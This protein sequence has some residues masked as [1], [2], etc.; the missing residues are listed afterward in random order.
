MYNTFKNHI[1]IKKGQ[2]TA[3]TYEVILEPYKGRWIPSLS[4][5]KLITND[6][7]IMEKSI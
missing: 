2:N 3:K 1:K 6:N 7:T 5:S 4:N